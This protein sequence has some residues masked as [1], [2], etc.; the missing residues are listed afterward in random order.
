MNPN[1]KKKKNND[2][3]K[4]HSV[5]KWPL[6]VLAISFAI[7][8]GF[9]VLSEISLSKA[10]IIVAI[11]VIFVFV[12]IAIVADMLSVAITA[13]DMKPFRAMASKKVRG[14]KDAISLKKNADKVASIFGDIVGDVC[15]I[16]SGAAGATVTLALTSNITGFGKIAIASLVSAIIAAIT[17]SGKAF[18]KRYSMDHAEAIVMRFAKFISF[19]HPNPDKKNKKV[20][21]HPAKVKDA[22]KEPNK[23]QS[24][25]ENTVSP[26]KLQ[27]ESQTYINKSEKAENLSGIENNDLVSSNQ[28]LSATQNQE[29]SIIQK[30]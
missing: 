19:F 1:P 26:T 6:T 10:G 29:N 11:I 2:K 25:I 7:C 4:S 20:K 8:L 27:K 23:N 24:N 5:V 30:D 21:N 15:G 13:C 22:V 3:T 12:F 16:L 14:A 28:N 18:M 9:G 17:I